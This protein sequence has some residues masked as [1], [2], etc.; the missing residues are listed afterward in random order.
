MTLALK[1]GTEWETVYRRARA[2]APEAFADDR[3]PALDLVR[4][5]DPAAL[6]VVGPMEDIPTVPTWSRGRA[7][8]IGDAAH[9]TS[10][11]SGKCSLLTGSTKSSMMPPQVSPTSKAVSSLMP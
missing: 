9:A 7:V 8:L 1:P 3:T 5:S 2:A 11:S 10:P 4:R 6:L